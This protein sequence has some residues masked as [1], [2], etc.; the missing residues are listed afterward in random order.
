MVKNTKSKSGKQVTIKN[1]INGTKLQ[2]VKRV[3]N[4]NGKQYNGKR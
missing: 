1:S 3:I 4:G 2:K